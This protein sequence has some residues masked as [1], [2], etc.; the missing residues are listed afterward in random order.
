MET[1]VAF[2]TATLC[3]MAPCSLVEGICLS[4]EASV[5]FFKVEIFE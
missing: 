5:N 2:I 4:V 1:D 3:D